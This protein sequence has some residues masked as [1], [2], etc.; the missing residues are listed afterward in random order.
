LN[1]CFFFFNKKENEVNQH[2]IEITCP[3]QT[4]QQQTERQEQAST[5]N[6]HMEDDDMPN[7]GNIYIF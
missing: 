4:D 5:N 7:D 1:F 6:N 3:S 2:P